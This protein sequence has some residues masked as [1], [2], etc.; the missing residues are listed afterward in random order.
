M[1]KGTVKKIR[2]A[3]GNGFI[4]RVDG[5]RDISFKIRANRYVPKPGEEVSFEIREGK[6]INLTPQSYNWQF[7]NP[8]NFVRP[9]NT[10]EID[11][12]IPH[13]Q[14]VYPGSDNNKKLYSGYIVCNLQIKT[15][16]FI[17]D[18]EKTIYRTVDQI[19][20]DD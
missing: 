6:A 18:P 14:F 4:E 7:I 19:S 5:G 11:K 8:Y 12:P 2:I 13:R 9:N 16:L 17:P 10:V 1:A 20:F 15:P 3:K